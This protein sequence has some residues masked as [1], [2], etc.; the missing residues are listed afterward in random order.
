MHDL[1]YLRSHRAEAEAAFAKK[2]VT[3]DLDAFYRLEEERVALLGTVEEEKRKRNA[4]SEE[5]G[6][7]SGRARTP[8]TCSP[9]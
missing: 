8:P 1:R 3:L 4:A 5:I 7:A 2:R 6:R 9:P